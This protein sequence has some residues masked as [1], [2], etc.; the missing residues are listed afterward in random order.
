MKYFLLHIKESKIK[1]RGKGKKSCYLGKNN[2]FIDLSI[3]P[4]DAI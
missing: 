3:V 1:C 2:P 4:V